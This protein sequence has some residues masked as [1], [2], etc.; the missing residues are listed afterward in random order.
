MVVD[1]IWLSNRKMN[2]KPLF[3]DSQ[4]ILKLAVSV[5]ARMLQFTKELW[6]LLKV[7]KTGKL[8]MHFNS[9]L[10]FSII[11]VCM[12]KSVRKWYIGSIFFFVF[13]S[14]ASYDSDT[15]MHSRANVTWMAVV[16][17]WIRYLKVPVALVVTL[18]SDF[19][20]RFPKPLYQV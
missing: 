15:S 3:C 14:P 8:L 20:I 1:V 7:F 16:E 5:A 12:L 17:N 18:S 6:K 13:C 4:R 2:R 9:I 11:R 10:S 19:A